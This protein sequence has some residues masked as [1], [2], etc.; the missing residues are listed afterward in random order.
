MHF[1]LQNGT[2]H[3]ERNNTDA[4]VVQELLELGIEKNEVILP[5]NAFAVSKIE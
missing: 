3:I 2:V 1:R 5:Y 4:E